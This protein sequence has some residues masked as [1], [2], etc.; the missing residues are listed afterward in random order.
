[1]EECEMSDDKGETNGIYIDGI[2]YSYSIKSEKNK[3]V[4]II[5]LYDSTNK[6][7]I[8]FTYIGNTSKLKK[9]I[10][11]LELFENL[12]EIITC[13]INI[14]DNG[15][16][17]VEKIPDLDIYNLKLQLNIFGIIRNSTIKLNKYTQK[18][19]SCIELK[20]KI[21]KLEN[22][23][24]DLLNKYKELQIIKENEI[25]KL[26][27]DVLFDKD[28]KIKFLDELEK[29]KLSKNN[30][31]LNHEDENKKNNNIKINLVK[32]NKNSNL[33]NFELNNLNEKD[34]PNKYM[35]EEEI[36][37]ETE[38][39]ANNIDEFFQF[40]KNIF[41]AINYD[42]TKLKINCEKEEI[43]ALVS[44][45]NKK[46]VKKEDINDY[47]LEKISLTFPQDILVNLKLAGQK[48]AKNLQKIFIFYKKGEHSNFSKFLET[49]KFKKNIVYTFSGYSENFIDENYKIN[50]NIVGE[51]KKENI[52]FIELNYNDT[53]REFE[54]CIDD[55]LKKD[56]LKVC[57]IKLFPYEGS[58]IK[59]INF[60]IE[61]KINKYKNKDKKIFIFIV[62]MSR[63]FFKEINN[64]EN[65]KLEEK[66][67]FNKKI[68][69]E[70]LSNLSGYYQIFI[71]NLKGDSRLKFENVLVMDNKGLFDNLINPDNQL[72]SNLFQIMGYMIYNIITPYKG[73]TVYNY[74]DKL[75]ELISNNKRLRCLINETIFNQWLKKYENIIST[76]FNKKLKIER[77]IEIIKVIENY[78]IEKY[79][80][81]FASIFFRAE[82][83]QFFS[84]LLTNSIEKKIFLKKENNKIEDINK[85]EEGIDIKNIE[86]K[87]DNTINE[88]ISKLYL[89]N[90]N[91]NDKKENAH[92]RLR[93]NKVDI[94][95]GLKIVGIKP[96]FD[97]ILNKH[98]EYILYNYLK[99]ENEMRN[100]IEDYDEIEKKRKIYF[101]ELFLL[102]N[103]LLNLIKKEK[104]FQVI[105]SFVQ[106]N[107]I[108]EKELYK[109]LLN[110]YYYYY[111]N[112]KIIKSK[113]KKE[114]RDEQ[115]DYYLMIDSFDNN[116]KFINLIFDIR[117]NIIN[118]YMDKK[119]ISNNNLYNFA[120]IINWIECYSDEVFI[121]QQLFLKLSIKIP[122]F[123]EKIEK[124]F[125]SIQNQYE[126]SERNTEY[127][128]IVNKPFL[129]IF[130][131]IIKIITTQT[132]I[133]ELP[134]LFKF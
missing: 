28:I 8:Y 66:E 117:Y 23:Y 124:I 130:D 100:Y 103:S 58:Y 122:K 101:E 49:L 46:G 125:S 74:V 96:I 55:Y 133:Y 33:N 126:I 97:I 106:K 48:Q 36:I 17:Q 83:D 41:K 73:I 99:N 107:E 45:A 132:E 27:K 29:L 40:D 78:L 89:E 62:Y 71:D 10:K 25:K 113:N 75:I 12:D 84:T 38:N 69:T 114:A 76:I 68:L 15:N 60:Y 4:L 20:D 3:E 102:N 129:L 120:Q 19:E 110:D 53:K 18:Q 44:D 86:E 1:M 115:D 30:L 14:F 92:K 26:V 65:K 22:K 57:I 82:K 9:D 105:L 42:L 85:M 31:N 61:T 77:E 24:E 59:Y 131:S 91:Y 94:I 111:L 43:Q 90:L 56:N 2:N 87:K 13:L 35:T 88:K 72:S 21:N 32:E 54:S 128:C 16:A 51:I 134:Q 47:V 123:F 67:Q 80:S 63:I 39:I 127:S 81:Q 108:E 93:S 37:N 34:I 50:N 104:N 6:S 118:R 11:F 95:L 119:D 109:S 79:L 98:K 5:K 121:L 70:T 116:I 64:I 112:N 7:N 52:K